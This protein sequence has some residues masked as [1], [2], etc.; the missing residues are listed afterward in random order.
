MVHKATNKTNKPIPREVSHKENYSEIM[1]K[2][3]ANFHDLMKFYL[4][5]EQRKEAKEA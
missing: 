3:D 4:S 1:G 2:I 5:K